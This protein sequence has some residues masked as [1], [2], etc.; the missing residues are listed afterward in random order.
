MELA[1]VPL[2]S[3][4]RISFGTPIIRSIPVPEKGDRASGS[5]LKSRT[6]DIPLDLRRSITVVAGGRLEATRP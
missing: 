5:G 6:L 3:V 2:A 1:T 4:G